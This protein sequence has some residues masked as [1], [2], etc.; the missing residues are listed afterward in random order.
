MVTT[1]FGGHSFGGDAAYVERLSSALAR[2][3][4]EVDVVHCA[5]AFEAVAAGRPL[6][7]FEPIDGVRVHMLKSRLGVL[8]P[9][10][11]HQLGKPGP[12]ARPLRRL[13]ESNPH[14]VVHFHNVSLI[15]APGILARP[16]PARTIRLMTAHEYWLVCPMHTL[17]KLD[18]EVCEKPQCV[19]CTIHGHRPPQLWRYGNAL[20]RSLEEL[21]ALI[22]PSRHATAMHRQR[23]VTRPIVHL[24]YF[25]P[26]GWAGPVA[27]ESP[28]GRSERPYVAAAGRLI[29][30]KGY[31]ELIALIDR[32]PEVDLRIAGTGPFEPELRRLAQSRPNV[33]LE[34]L[35]SAG[36]LAQLFRGA[37]AVVVPSLLY[38]TFGYVVLE[39]L[40]VG[41][42]A[43]VRRQGALAELIDESGGGLAFEN[44]D[45]AVEQL[46]R[47]ATDDEL[48]DRLAAAGRETLR[49]TWSE[50]TQVDTYLELVDELRTTASTRA[51]ADRRAAA[52]RSRARV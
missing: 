31:H 17:W 23:G 51:S 50:Q 18:R 22:C 47:L 38:E 39:A 8:S 10:W 7:P 19:R 12:K 37:R 4:H 6:R 48:R 52:G 13:L 30:A 49:T 28:N 16:L 20:D 1:F 43:I 34:G 25:L 40:S 33:H 45:E 42:P 14:D 21:D 9:L 26:E 36:Q 29:A 35:L 24:P 46:R 3:G 11:S 32:L 15:G 41:T 5:D 44:D 27:R 2:R